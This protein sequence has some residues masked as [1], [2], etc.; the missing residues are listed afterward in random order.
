VV[1]VVVVSDMVILYS[2]GEPAIVSARWLKPRGPLSGFRPRQYS[3][4]PPIPL[5]GAGLRV[6]TG[7][8]GERLR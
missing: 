8:S 6:L 3:G 2:I 4:P 1:V 5:P 7:L